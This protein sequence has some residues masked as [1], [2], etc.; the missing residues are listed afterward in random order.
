M[1]AAQG[2]AHRDADWLSEAI[3]RPIR[4]PEEVYAE[5]RAVSLTRAAAVLGV[6]GDIVIGHEPA[7]VPVSGSGPH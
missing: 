1:D 4:V 5:Q 2:G 3:G 6:V 7:G